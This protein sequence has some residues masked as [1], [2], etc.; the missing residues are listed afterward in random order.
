[1]PKALDNRAQFR[2]SY[3]RLIDGKRCV[4][5]VERL[6]RLAA[7]LP[8]E[9]VAVSVLHESDADLWFDG[10]PPTIRC[11]AEHCR[12]IVGAD[13]EW[14]IILSAEGHLMDGGHRV[15]RALLEGCTS[16][17]ATRFV[18]TPPP[19]L[20]EQTG[21]VGDIM[22]AERNLFERLFKLW[23]TISKDVVDGKKDPQRL[24][25]LLQS[26]MQERHP[27]DRHG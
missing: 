26:F 6:W 12:R 24:A 11:I 15:A 7:C 25:D 21:N 16:L 8:V 5:D 18:T 19:D 14:P 13:L 20:V 10:S 4:W 22:N 9:E 17:R 2:R 23:A 27:R 1:M 3:S